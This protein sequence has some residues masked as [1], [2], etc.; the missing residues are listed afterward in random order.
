LYKFKVTVNAAFL[1]EIMPRFFGV[2]LVE[3]EEFLS[4]QQLE[5]FWCNSVIQHTFLGADRTITHHH[6]VESG[7]NAEFDAPAMATAVIESHKITHLT[8]VVLG[9]MSAAHLR[10]FA[11]NIA[12]TL[13]DENLLP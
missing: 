11:E 10:R 9:F 8:T 6:F 2:E 7:G 4:C 13:N 3:G 5:V 1:A 12:P